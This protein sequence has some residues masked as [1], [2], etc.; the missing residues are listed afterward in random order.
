M[1]RIFVAAVL[2]VLALGLSARGYADPG[3][4]AELLAAHN[5]YRASLGLPPLRWSNRLA[6][7]A[8]RW[9]DHLAAIGSLEHSGSGQNLAM[10]AS[11]TQSLRQLVDLWGSE[12]AYFVDGYFP[13]I[14]TTGNWVNVGHYSQMIWRMTTEV[15][16]GFAR[17]NGY[18]VLVCNYNPPGNVMGE[19][20]F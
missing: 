13:A 19:R 15:G 7:S 17:N 6:A 9:A 5:S 20:A 10:A 8:Q 14:S 12:R 3:T 16:C 1:T 11:G 4:T 18:D 2:V